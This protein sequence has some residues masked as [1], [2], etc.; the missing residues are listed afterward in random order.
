MAGRWR[1][2]FLLSGSY[3]GHQK[4]KP[5]KDWGSQ[6]GPLIG[7]LSHE[8][9]QMELPYGRENKSQFRRYAAKILL[10]PLL[11]FE[12]EDQ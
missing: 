4:D 5:A 8:D 6:Q 2:V 10:D 1:R 11:N 9:L 7:M 12:I 3:R